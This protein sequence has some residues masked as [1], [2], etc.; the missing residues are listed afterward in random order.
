MPAIYH[1]EHIVQD[2]E[3]DELGHVNNLA[4]LKWMQS[5]AIEHSTAQGW[6]PE[7]YVESGSGWVVRSHFIEYQQAAYAGERIVVVTWVANFKKITSLRKFKITR[8]QD[9]QILAVAETNWAYIG[10]KHYVPRRIPQELIESFEI[11]PEEQE[12]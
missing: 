11:V 3:I 12:P 9:D 10:T 5:A 8:P 1:L 6:A 4:Y 7:R 2:D